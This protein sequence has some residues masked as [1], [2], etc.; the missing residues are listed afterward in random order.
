MCTST[1][2]ETLTCRLQ[3][4]DG[5]VASGLSVQCTGTDDAGTRADDDGRI[6]LTVLVTHGGFAGWSS[7]CGALELRDDAGVLDATLDGQRDI[8]AQQLDRPQARDGGCRIVVE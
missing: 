3:R 2:S 4:S 6:S 1:R 8:G 5:G 7:G